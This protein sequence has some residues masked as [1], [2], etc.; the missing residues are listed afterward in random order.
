[1]TP[2]M[3]YMLILDQM[4]V[5]Y[6]LSGAYSIPVKIILNIAQYV[7]A[8]IFG[9]VFALVL[10]CLVKSIWNGLGLGFMFGIIWWILTPF[11][12][13]PFFFVVS[14]N[15]QWEDLIMYELLDSLISYVIFGLVLGFFYALFCMLLRRQA[16]RG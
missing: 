16:R 5:F 7:T 13:F 8:I 6:L 1:M 14:P 10:H 9:I 11:Y 2:A 4:K 15:A 12:L 3:L